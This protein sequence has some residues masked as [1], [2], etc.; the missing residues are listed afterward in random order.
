M[1]FS[2]TGLF[3]LAGEISAPVISLLCKLQ[4]LLVRPV[5]C[6]QF[7][8]PEIAETR[9]LKNTNT[10]SH[11]GLRDTK[12]LRPSLPVASATVGKKISP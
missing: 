4:L 5:N 10:V 12:E 2:L 7:L 6:P 3:P 8:I 9:N 11:R 1:T